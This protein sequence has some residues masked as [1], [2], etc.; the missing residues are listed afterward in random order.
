M[1]YLT[2][3]DSKYFFTKIACSIQFNLFCRES[4]SM[5]KYFILFF[6]LISNLA[7]A[8][9]DEEA[10]KKTSNKKALQ[11][12]DQAKKEKD[13]EKSTELVNEA[14]SEEAQFPEAYMFLASRAMKRNN[15]QLTLKLK[16]AEVEENIALMESS[17]KKLIEICPSFSEKPYLDLGIYYFVKQ[18][19]E[20]AIKYLRDYKKHE[21][22]KEA[23]LAYAD[24]LMRVARL[25][26]SPVPYQP[27]PLMNICSEK[28]EYLP[29][30]S[31]DNELVFF[32]RAYDKLRRGDLYPT[33]VEEF[34]MGI[35]DSV[36]GQYSY[37]EA[38]SK[39][40]NL[41]NNEG[42][43]SISI[44]NEVMYFTIC[45]STTGYVNCDV[46]YTEKKNGEW[47]EI[48]NMGP[49]VNASNAW[50]SQPCISRDGNTLYFSSDRNEATNADIYYT[51]KDSKGKWSPAQPL[52]APFNTK[53]NDKSPFLHPDNQTLYF[54]SDGLSGMGGFDIYF[55]K[56]DSTG[57]WTTPK[58]LGYPINTTNDE[59]GFFVSTD[60]NS[61]YFASN[62][63][64]GAGKGGYDVYTF[65]LYDGARPG[66]V[67]FVKGGLNK[68]DRDTTLPMGSVEIKNTK[69][70]E[71]T[72]LDV[73]SATGKFVGVV[74]FEQ[75]MIVTMKREGYAF[76]SS[77][78]SVADS[79]TIKP[80][81]LEMDLKKV[82]VG[83]VFTLKNIFYKSNSADLTEESIFVV[84]EFVEY[85]K[86]NPSLKVEIRGH[87]DNVGDDKKNLALSTDRAFTVYDLALEAGLLKT[88]IGF[89]G[90]GKTKPVAEN[91]SEEGR[92]KN[93]RTEF[94][95]VSK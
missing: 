77:Y 14:I 30:I 31:A 11:I 92:A 40:F 64:K 36:S 85:L 76:E 48:K 33:K 45:K 88:R 82:E 18:N 20:E 59:L 56:K 93:R 39:P 78:I 47:G 68:D 44:N 24:S 15:L 52:G 16:K 34:T 95:I 19:Y 63:L 35:L 13:W 5:Y 10:C 46:W 90:F 23:D 65:P 74:N 79:G 58:N 22:A 41:N 37:G 91:D 12:F 55:S 71:I 70:N 9:E 73:D 6:V 83:G 49:E 42:G 3:K 1:S 66:R 50:D 94:V 62:K 26:K 8:Q 81:K 54:S 28:D 7:F 29:I 43:A 17:Y 72:K 69:T 86:E 75:D 32:T 80:V 87:T 57:N 67:L 60:G 27:K 89:K 51:T 4:F 53:G 38:L 84:K 21:K 2:Q 61:G 25:L